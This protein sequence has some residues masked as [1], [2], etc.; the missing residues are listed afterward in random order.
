MSFNS[1]KAL[2]V[3]V[4]SGLLLC[5]ATTGQAQG[6]QPEKKKGFDAKEI[7]FGHVLNA[8]YFHFMDIEHKDGSVTRISIPLPVFLYSSKRGF[9]AFIEGI[10][11]SVAIKPRS[12]C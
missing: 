10:F 4:F 5:A 12:V 2:L 8:H 1:I 7:I 11:V 3:L 6:K 9:A